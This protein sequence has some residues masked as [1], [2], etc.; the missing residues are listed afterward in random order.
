MSTEPDPL[1]HISVPEFRV[2][3]GGIL[4]PPP[5]E[6]GSLAARLVQD[7][8][9]LVAAWV[10]TVA[11]YTGAAIDEAVEIALDNGWDVH[12][13]RPPTGY[14]SDDLTLHR[15]AYIGIAFEPGLYGIPV[16][17]MHEHHRDPDWDDIDLDMD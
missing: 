5:P 2:T 9:D 11:E 1:S 16:I 17:H 8:K 15:M 4:F 6:P 3:R 10:R 14:R 13:Y 12:V 7:R